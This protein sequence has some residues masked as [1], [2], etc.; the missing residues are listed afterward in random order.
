MPL[1]NR[2]LNSYDKTVNIAP[3]GRISVF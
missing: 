1:L 2:L 3:L